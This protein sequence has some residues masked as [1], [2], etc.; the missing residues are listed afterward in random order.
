MGCCKHFR[1]NR[2]CALRK[3]LKPFSSS[4]DDCLKKINELISNL[5]E[6]AWQNRYFEKLD[7]GVADENVSGLMNSLIQ[8]HLLLAR[9]YE[10]MQ[11][12]K[13]RATVKSNDLLEPIFADNLH[14]IT[15]KSS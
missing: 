1:L 14:N 3:E 9:L 7:G 15:M 13:D 4:P 5:E 11:P 8:Y 10:E 12:S 2:V 6:R